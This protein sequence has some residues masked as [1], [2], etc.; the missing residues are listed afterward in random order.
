MK[1]FSGILCLLVFAILSCSK[2]DDSEIWDYVKEMN[3]RLTQLEEKCK[4]MNTNI[5]SLQTLVGAFENGDYITNVAPVTKDGKTI[6]YTISFKKSTAITI[7]NGTDGVN[8]TNGVNGS[9]GY[10][11]VIGIKKDTDGLYYWTVDG[12]WLL[13]NKGNKVR[14]SAGKAARV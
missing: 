5:T 13:D 12:E 14:A 1:K 2:Y 3:A 9:D 7:Y 6:G 11:P 10:T 8:G 4:E